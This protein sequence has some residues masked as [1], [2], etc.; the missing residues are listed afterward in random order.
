[1]DILSESSRRIHGMLTDKAE[2]R[3]SWI[4]KLY[5]KQFP[6]VITGLY[7]LVGGLWI[8]FSDQMLWAVS[9]SPETYSRWQ[10]YKGWFYVLFTGAAL[11]HFSRVYVSRHRQA[12]ERLHRSE[13][14]LRSLF[15]SAG[16]AVFLYEQEGKI[17]EVNREAVRLLG[18]SREELL[19]MDRD[20]IDPDRAGLSD[21]EDSGWK[22]GHHD[23]IVETEY[24]TRSGQRIP[25]E[26]SRRTIKYQGR[27]V[28]LNIARDISERKQV[29]KALVKSEERYRLLA[30]TT[31]DLICIH[32]MAGEITFLNH[33]ALDFTGY[34]REDAYQ[35]HIREFVPPEEVHEMQRRREHR[36]A[37]HDLR[38]RYQTRFINQRGRAVP[39]EVSSAPIL[40]NGQPAE[41][42]LIA[43]DI[44]K[45]V[46]AEKKVREYSER[47]EQLVEDR[48]EALQEAREK[49][50]QKEKM[51]V[52][53]Q[54]A[55]S[56]SH[57]LRNPLA[58]MSNAVYYLKLAEPDPAPKVEEY[59]EILEDEIDQ[60]AKIVADLLD[61]S[62][63]KP[64]DQEAVSLDLMVHQVRD[65]LNLPDRIRWQ[66][67]IPRG[68]PRVQVDPGHL[69]QILL[70]LLTNAS[71][72]M[73]TGGVVTVSA[74][75]R[76]QDL[77]IRIRD[78]GTGIALEHQDKIFEPL[79]TTKERGIGLG[80]AITRRL[81]Q[82]NQGTIDFKSQE[83]EGTLFLVHLPVA[84]EKA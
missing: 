59:L 35:R 80:L 47:L 21:P 1:M 15:D 81:V 42:L 37:G 75:D 17:L 70:N 76:G 13:E 78:T 56:V 18:Y 7:I 31:Q 51:A 11:Y 58:V 6:L 25:I 27:E 30:E 8:L 36:A 71:Q 49:L 43:R 28:I 63:I 16:D 54:M 46:K 45:R 5:R 26:V 10:T 14:S 68:L 72:A 69:K 40:K 48:T 55:G 38:V 57:E 61:F 32:N 41:I 19:T 82:V 9:P 79:F 33:A 2:G 52:L 64:P 62:R 50:F 3:K 74:L 22:A 20:E 29:Q 84:E 44:T 23:L 67:E 53:G 24:L 34:S 39:V 66:V 4:G 60:A 77:Q 73:P 65:D 12:E 83:G